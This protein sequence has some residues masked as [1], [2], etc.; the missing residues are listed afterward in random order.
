M[1]GAVNSH[2]LVINLQNLLPLLCILSLETINIPGLE[3]PYLM[4]LGLCITL[5]YNFSQTLLWRCELCAVSQCC[6]LSV[7]TSLQSSLFF[8]FTIYSQ[9]F[10]EDNLTVKIFHPYLETFSL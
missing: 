7:P 10:Y 2:I 8:Q 3:L 5:S 4:I 6:E 9:S 1:D